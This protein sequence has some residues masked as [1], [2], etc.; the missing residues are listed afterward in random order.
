V[1]QGRRDAISFRAIPIIVALLL[2]KVGGNANGG[3]NK[4][5][6]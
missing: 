3:G 1:E 5:K 4:R 2:L 6:Q